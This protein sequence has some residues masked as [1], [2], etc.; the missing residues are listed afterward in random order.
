LQGEQNILDARYL[1]VNRL[2]S[3]CIQRLGLND[4]G[5]IRAYMS[6]QMHPGSHRFSH[7]R[8]LKYVPKEAWALTEERIF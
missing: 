7:L 6:S 8:S 4:I 3:K 1:V 2:A 5:H